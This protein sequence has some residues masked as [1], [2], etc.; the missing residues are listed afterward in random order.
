MEKNLH[1]LTKEDFIK[2]I[3]DYQEN[4]KEID[5]ITN[6]LPCFYELIPVE[7]GNLMFEKV[8]ETYF[9]EE[10][11]DS[12][13]WWLF[14]KDGNPEYKMWDENDQEIPTETIEDLWNIVK[15]YKK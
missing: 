13:F 2:L 5:K 6:I 3:E 4:R 14:E 15:E 10:G 8:I 9:K 1:V 7:Y 11:V 12:I